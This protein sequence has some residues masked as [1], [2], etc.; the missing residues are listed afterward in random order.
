MKTSVA[1]LAALLSCLIAFPA[2]ATTAADETAGSVGINY[3]ENGVIGIQWEFDVSTMANDQPFSVQAFWKNVSQDLSGGETWDTTG[4]G[5]AM[6]YDFNAVAKLDKT[7]HPYVGI[8]VMSI[9]YNWTGSG[10]APTYRGI[11]SGLYLAGGLRY[12]FSPQWAADVNFNL[13]GNLTAGVNYS[14]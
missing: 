6:V 8:G 11:G 12:E 10:P 9:S 13:F 14:F 1:L 4:I 3:G 2:I 5:V 7:I